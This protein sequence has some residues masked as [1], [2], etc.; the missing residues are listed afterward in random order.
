MYKSAIAWEGRSLFDRAPIAVVVTNIGNVYSRNPKCGKYMAQATIL[1]TDMHPQD[2]I[3]TGK[4]YAVCAD[5]KHRGRCATNS[6]G[7]LVSTRSCYVVIKG[8]HLDLPRG[9][10]RLLPPHGPPFDQQVRGVNYFCR[11]ATTISAGEG[12]AKECWSRPDRTR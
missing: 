2:A 3:L 1:R 4:D 12:S 6:R 5:C 7:T 8:D 9:K 10:E 11:L